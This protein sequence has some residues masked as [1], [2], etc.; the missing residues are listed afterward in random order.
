VS[1]TSPQDARSHLATLIGQTIRT[2]TGR[3]NEVV[4][5]DGDSVLV[6]TS[7]SAPEAAPV[8][9][10]WVHDAFDRLWRDGGIDVDVASLGYRSAF[11]GAV[12]LTLPGAV[13]KSS[14]PPRVELAGR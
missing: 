7:R 6:R 2:V 12:L 14:A 8:P 1:A 10:A 11:I 5:I 4:S 13:L 3:P 9:I